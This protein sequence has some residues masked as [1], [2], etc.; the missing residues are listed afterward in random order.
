MRTFPPHS[1]RGGHSKAYT[2][3]LDCNN[4]LVRTN[5][6]IQHI[7]SVK[8]RIANFYHS[9]SK[10][11]NALW[12]LAQVLVTNNRF[13]VDC[14]CCSSSYSY[15]IFDCITIDYFHGCSYEDLQCF[16][17]GTVFVHVHLQTN[18]RDDGKFFY[19]RLN[20]DSLQ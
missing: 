4:K 15:Y 10:V 20:I 19:T 12:I 17:L 16:C 8:G 14:I 9:K 3:S 6:E 18:E 13:L 1:N 5:Y 2:F 7:M 11:A